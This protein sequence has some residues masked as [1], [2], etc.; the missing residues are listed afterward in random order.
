MRTFWRLL[1]F[2]R[3]YRKGVT[4]SFALAAVAMAAGVLIPYLVGRTVDE[5]RQGETNLWPL[6]AA[7][8]GAGVLRARV[9]RRQAPRRRAHLARRRV[10]PAQPDVRAPPV[11]RARVLRLAADG[12]ADVA[13]DGRPAGRSLL[14][15]LRARVHPPVRADDPDRG[16]RDARGE[17]APGRGGAGPRAVRRRD[18]HA[19][20]PLEP[21][22]QPG[23]AAADRGAHGRGRGERLGRA[24]GEGLRAGGAAAR[25]LPQGGA[26]RVRPVDGLDAAARVLQPV[27]RVSAA[28]RARRAAAGRR[29]AGDQRIDHRRRVR[30]LLRVCPDADVTDADA[31]HRPRNGP[32]RGGVRRARLRDPRPIAADDRAGGR[33]APAGRPRRGALRARHVRVRRRRA[34]AVRGQP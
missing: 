11:A 16:S 4:R 33:A 31:R 17:P 23:G 25:A 7:I 19:L 29:P 32:A 13:L 1:G 21:A 10:R 27:H 8:V 24:G 3:P 12:P 34:G 18:R 28:A 5:I 20:R 9:Q 15:G 26:A 6:A 22:G 30:R 2:L 14:P